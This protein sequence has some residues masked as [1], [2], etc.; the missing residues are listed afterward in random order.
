MNLP[1][2]VIDVAPRGPGWLVRVSGDGLSAEFAMESMTVDCDDR[3][4]TV[5]HRG[6]IDGV[7]LGKR[8]TRIE[9]RRT[10]D[11]DVYAYG[12]WLFT[13]LLEPVWADIVDL[14]CVKEAKGVE[15]AL[16]WP[17]DQVVLHQ[18]TWEAMCHNG[19]PLAN[20]AGLLVGITRLVPRQ[21]RALDT[22]QRTPR[23]L[24]AV[25]GALLD[26]TIRP[27][28]MFMGLLRA[29]DADGVCAAKAVQG[30]KVED[31]ARHCAEFQPDVVHLV[32]HGDVVDGRGAIRLAD[33]WANADVLVPALTS[34]G[35]SPIAVV[36]SACRTGSGETAEPMPSG[37]LAAEL[38]ARGIPIVSAVA[39][40]VSEQACRL[41]SRRLVEAISDG[42]P[43]AK[44]VA[45]GRRAALSRIEPGRQ[46]DWAMPALFVAESV[47]PDFRPVNREAAAWLIKAA[48]DL[49]LRQ[50]PVFIGRAAILEH[51]DDMFDLRRPL[52]VIGVVRHG[53]L[54]GLGGT[55][56]L[57]EMGYQLLMRGHVP[58]VLGPYA[59]TKSPADL[60]GFVAEV[61]GS[62]LRLAEEFELTLPRFKLLDPYYPESVQ[63]G[64]LEA[65]TLA[66]D[67]FVRAP[68]RLVAGL[69]RLSLGHDLAAFAEVTEALGE[70]FG[71][72]SRVVLLADEIH[73][74]PFVEELIAIL[75]E[76][77]EKGLGRPDRAAPFVFTASLAENECGPLLRSFSEVKYGQP[78]YAFPPLEALDDDEALLGFQWILL[79]PWRRDTEAERKVYAAKP[80]ADRDFVR[81]LFDMLDG[82]PAHVRNPLFY[83]VAHSLQLSGAFVA[84]DDF[85]TWTR[86]LGLMR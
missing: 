38:V 19:I 65:L 50:A 69:V 16:R 30:V 82:K 39:G 53:S 18:M 72:H 70:P 23:V 75:R 85:A 33:G 60:R 67:G 77:G 15:L 1:R 41:Y 11:G 81:S 83:K 28:A 68:D 71:T 49:Q 13:C 74:W 32:A 55:R 27:G 43:L 47:A 20:D 76:A 58:L 64:S 42:T 48:R 66:L 40:E 52:G 7:E 5:P 22:I 86:Y 4:L 35:A 8:L 59:P 84:D 17:L 6:E 61:F 44:A 2:I 3:E 9:N 10:G 63:E 24:F 57:R 45:E 54:S 34:G 79:N 14:P 26:D 29:F 62:V 21:A 12:E 73:R 56:L 78:G 36:L 37:P 80:D 25:G 46:L 31:L 51:V